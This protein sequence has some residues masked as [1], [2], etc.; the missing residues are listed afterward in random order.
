MGARGSIRHVTIAATMKQKPPPTFG[1]RIAVAL[2]GGFCFIVAAIVTWRM[3]PLAHA[4]P[5]VASQP[6]SSPSPA[7]SAQA[8]PR[9]PAVA[10]ALGWRRGGQRAGRAGGRARR[11][12]AGRRRGDGG[13]GADVRRAAGAH[14]RGRHAGARSRATLGRTISPLGG[15]RSRAHHRDGRGRDR[16]SAGRW[17]WWAGR[18]PPFSRGGPTRST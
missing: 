4:D 9:W 8:D 11:A 17:C 14:A 10:E 3:L 1:V 16:R 18:R 12:A 2:G 15:G 13:A 7:S 6:C 5:G